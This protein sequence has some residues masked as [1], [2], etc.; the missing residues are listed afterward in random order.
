MP[1]IVPLVLVILMPFVLPAVWL[2]GAVL[3]AVLQPRGWRAT[4]AMS[5]G[6][7]YL[8]M[9]VYAQTIDGGFPAPVGYPLAALSLLGCFVATHRILSR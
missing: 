2:S 4:L 5:L 1:S 9:W 8:P 6:G 7:L 3:V